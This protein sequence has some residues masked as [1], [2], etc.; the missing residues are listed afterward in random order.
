MTTTRH[1]TSVKRCKITT[2]GCKM[3]LYHTDRFKRKQ[4][5]SKGTQ[6]D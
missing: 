4:N 1:Q 5:D 6:N 3:T 2:L